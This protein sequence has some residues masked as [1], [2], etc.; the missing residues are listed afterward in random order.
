L[1]SE[2]ERLWT[3]VL[4]YDLRIYTPRVLPDPNICSSGSSIQNTT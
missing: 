1:A 2:K 3:A 4:R